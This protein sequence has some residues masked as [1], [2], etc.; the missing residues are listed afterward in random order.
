MV[1][2]RT[3][4]HGSAP[5]AVLCLSLLFCALSANIVGAEDVFVANDTRAASL[6]SVRSSSPDASGRNDLVAKT[7]SGRS[8][9][10]ATLDKE[11]VTR[12]DKKTDLS[13][14]GGLSL[15]RGAAALLAVLVLIIALAVLWRRFNPGARAWTQAGCMQVLVRTSITP[16]QSLCLIK[17]GNR[18]LLLGISPNHIASV[19][20]IDDPEE[21]THLLGLIESR[22]ANSISA[23]FNGIINREKQSYAIDED[24]FDLTESDNV[25]DEFPKYSKAKGELTNLLQKVKGLSRISFRS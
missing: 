16:K 14:P 20:T 10:G 13:D 11:L 2:R 9:L 21:I 7:A 4:H 8:L 17:L 24:G 15:W 6:D 19:A 25:R 12:S 1:Y 23:T 5:V 18:L 3:N 22:S